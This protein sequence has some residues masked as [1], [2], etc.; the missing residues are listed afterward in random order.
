MKQALVLIATMLTSSIALAEPPET[1]RIASI[2]MEVKDDINQNLDR[3][4]K[5]IQEAKAAGARVVTFP[6][7]ALS[8]FF[9]E[10][11]QSL[12]WDTLA[13]AEK[14][15]AATAKENGL[16]VIHGSAT[17][18][19]KERPYNSA[20]VVG[21]DGAEITRYYKMAP[22]KHFEPGDHLALFEIDGV[23][24]T[25]IICH[26]ER[27]PEL[28]RIPVMSGA[29]ICFYIGYEVNSL[30][31]S[32]Q[33]MDNYR[34]QLM[35]RAAENNIWVLDCSAI[36][37]LEGNGEHMSL[38]LSRYFDPSGKIVAEAPPLKDTMIIA[39]IKPA[40]AK[41]SNA[42]ETLNYPA[43]AS[44]WKQGQ[45]LIG[46]PVAKAEPTP[47]E[48]ST[49]RLGLMK[50]VP[51]KWDLE[52]NFNVFMDLLNKASEQ[53]V[54]LFI[55]PECWL[56]GYAVADK[57]STVERLRGIAQALDDSSYLKRV[58]EEAKNRKMYI[59]FGFTSSENGNIYN[60]SA[61]FD[62]SGN[63]VGVYHKTHLQQHDLQFSAGDALPVF[64]T[65][66]G[67]LGIMICADRRWPETARTLRLEG[68]KLILNPSYGMHGESNEMWMRTRS[69]ENQCF[70][71]FTHPEMSLVTNPK[72]NISGKDDT[73]GPT[74]LVSDIDLTEAKDNNHIADR[75]PELYKAI[76]DSR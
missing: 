20:V 5:G 44:F 65:P 52:A 58:A 70:I 55:T 50:A 61:L 34:S 43:L 56:D 48:R 3:I 68:A 32:V 35:A 33:K 64:K 31:G 69:Y 51:V 75:R 8:G 67:P 23:P 66:W 30:T 28:V 11:I 45:N 2:Q 14:K 59:C 17:K 53:K 21:P 6:E 39:D 41:R 73:V 54:E 60:T 46:A 16:Y 62:D 40:A 25:M 71:A 37:P 72:G 38:G 63:R 76:T 19:G 10:A 26:D 18:S 22:E 1:L 74:L 12:N 9:K 57:E 24:C 27:F 47:A 4:L 36:G 7:T 49:A 42:I 29:V 13:E 15:I